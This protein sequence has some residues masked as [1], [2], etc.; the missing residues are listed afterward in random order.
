MYEGTQRAEWQGGTCGDLLFKRSFWMFCGESTGGETETDVKRPVQVGWCSSD[1][2]G[3]S[4][5][6]D[7][8]SGSKGAAFEK[9][10][11]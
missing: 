8:G 3:G 5:K 2:Q 11:R 1:R 10:K 4:M 6:S 7:S 9:L